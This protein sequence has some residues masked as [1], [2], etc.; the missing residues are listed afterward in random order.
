MT[1]LFIFGLGLLVI[2]F[3]WA[4]SLR[5]IGYIARFITREVL[6]EIN[7]AQSDQSTDEHRQN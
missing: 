6:D 7:K 3:A 1:Y 2:I 5:L 4:L